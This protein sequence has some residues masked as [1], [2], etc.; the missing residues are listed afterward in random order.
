MDK[1]EQIDIYYEIPKEEFMMIKGKPVKDTTPAF[2][3][4]IECVKYFTN[5][6]SKVIDK[7]CEDIRPDFYDYTEVRMCKILV[8]EPPVPLGQCGRKKEEIEDDLY[9]VLTGNFGV[10]FMVKIVK[11]QINICWEIETERW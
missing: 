4:V 2:I 5:W 8:L 11:N 6:D 1:Y 7:K 3:D 10:E 9:R